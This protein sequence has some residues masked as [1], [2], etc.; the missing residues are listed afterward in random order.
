[1]VDALTISLTGMAVVFVVLGVLVF[2]IMGM[3][4]ISRTG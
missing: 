3:E 2:V 1:M 4:R